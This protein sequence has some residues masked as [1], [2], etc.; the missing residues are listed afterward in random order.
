MAQALEGRP[1]MDRTTLLIFAAIGI[2]L[3]FAYKA[4]QTLVTTTQRLTGTGS[5][6][7][8]LAA[9]GTQGLLG[10]LFSGKSS[11]NVKVT[12]TSG[13]YTPDI[14]QGQYGH[15]ATAAGDSTDSSEID[16][17]NDLDPDALIPP[18]L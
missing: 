18:D 5:I 16:P 6:T 15:T 12:S 10:W 1:L 17:T 14:A 13:G 9:G 8:Q 7:Q 3:Y 11:G 4:K 2:V